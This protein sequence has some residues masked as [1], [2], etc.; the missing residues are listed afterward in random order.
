MLVGLYFSH[1]CN[2][3]RPTLHEE[4]SEH[5]RFVF[6][7]AASGHH[8]FVVG[9]P[10][11]EADP[12][13]DRLARTISD[14]PGAGLVIAAGFKKNRLGVNRP[15]ARAYDSLDVAPEARRA[16]SVYQ[17]F[18][19]IVSA[20]AVGNLEFYIGIHTATSL[21]PP[22]L[23]AMSSGLSFEQA[24]AIKRVYQNL[25]DETVQ[26]DATPKLE[27]TLDPLV[28]VAWAAECVKH[29]GILLAAEKGMMLRLPYLSAESEKIYAE[30]LC[31]R[32]ASCTGTALATRRFSGSCNG[33][34]HNI[35]AVWP[36]ASAIFG[37]KRR[38][39]NQIWMVA[40]Q[41]R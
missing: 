16:A 39:F 11:G 3:Y 34:A 24:A 10:H 37:W 20:A 8:G 28:T 17:D 30:I 41:L 19:K 7:E 40:L 21:F 13:S 31:R 12:G 33:S 36:D 27:M 38:L 25:R 5:G 26:D 1:G 14:R 35:P 23:E 4:R 29:H 2:F 32:K 22:R 9:A 6:R 18:K 15:L